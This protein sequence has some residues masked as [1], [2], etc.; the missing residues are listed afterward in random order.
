MDNTILMA[1]N[2]ITIILKVN[3]IISQNRHISIEYLNSII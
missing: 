2:V 3:S 1:R